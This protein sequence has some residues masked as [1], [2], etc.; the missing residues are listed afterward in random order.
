MLSD[1]SL[2]RYS[3]QLMLPAVDVAGQERLLASRVLLVGAG[4]LGCP[5]ALYLGAAGVGTLFIADDDRVDLSNLQRQLAYTQAD[6]GRPKA[7]VLREAV[8]ARNP[9]I[10]VEALAERLDAGRLAVLLADVDVVVDASDNAATRLAVNAACVQAR[11]PLVSGA[12]IRLE[13]QLAVFDPRSADA[14]CYRCLVSGQPDEDGACARN[15]VLSPVVGVIGALQAVEALKL[16]VP[17]GA[18]AAGRLLV[19]DGMQG[20]WRAFRIPRDPHCPVC[21]RE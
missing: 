13:G 12:A 7:D 21:H 18:P 15:G 20:Q 11:K 19:Y 16:L 5:V 17:M 4:G 1:E 10:R 14:A 3:R 6:I 9:G 8:L 2:L